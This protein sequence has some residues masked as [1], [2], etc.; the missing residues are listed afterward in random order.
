MHGFP[1]FDKAR[2]MELR[3][4]ELT[5]SQIAKRLG[6]TIGAVSHLFRE[7]DE[8]SKSLHKQTDILQVILGNNQH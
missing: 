3:S 4:K 1:K 6:V 2:A 7:Q 5:T 8:L